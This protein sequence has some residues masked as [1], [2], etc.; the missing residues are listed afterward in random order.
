MYY[1]TQ[2]LEFLNEYYFVEYKL[3]IWF[4]ISFYMGSN[5]IC[6]ILYY[7]LCTHSDLYLVL[8]GLKHSILLTFLQNGN[9]YNISID[10]L[11][12]FVIPT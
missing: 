2:L 9:I 4:S 3:H 11:L 10:F 7:L 5:N 6:T 1:T 8:P 12:K